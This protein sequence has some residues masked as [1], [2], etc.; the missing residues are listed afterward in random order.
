MHDRVG[1]CQLLEC[2][3]EPVASRDSPERDY[4]VSRPSPRRLLTSSFALMVLAA[5]F[6][7]LLAHQPTI[8]ALAIA[9][10]MLATLAGLVT[11]W[12]P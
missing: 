12:S 7:W 3:G 5:S 6:A 11:L 10:A 9:N 8:Q 2:A 4:V 1:R